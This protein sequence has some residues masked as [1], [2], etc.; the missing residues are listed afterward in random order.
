DRFIVRDGSA[1]RTIAGGSVLDPFAPERYRRSADRLAVLRA[2]EAATPE[3]RLGE[4]LDRAADGVDLARFARSHNV[5]DRDALA[6]VMPARRVVNGIA[7][8]VIDPR[9]WEALGEQVLATLAAFHTAHPDELGP[10]AGRLKRMAFP[11]LD[12]ALYRA[13]VDDLIVTHRV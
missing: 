9:H 6:S 12:A 10:D 11:R 5:S 7:D 4:L 8:F 2:L 13:L 1:T 3:F